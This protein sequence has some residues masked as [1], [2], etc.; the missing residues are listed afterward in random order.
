MIEE[1]HFQTVGPDPVLG[2]GQNPGNP[3]AGVFEPEN[4]A[5]RSAPVRRENVEITVVVHI[6]RHQ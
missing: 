2:P 6:R 5:I 3:R 4:T 1:H